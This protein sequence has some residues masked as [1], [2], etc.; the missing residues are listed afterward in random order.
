MIS[1]ADKLFIIDT[2]SKHKAVRVLLFGSGVEASRES[3]DIDLG[4]EGIPPR[5][6]F[7]FYGELIFGLSKPVDLVDITRES[8][9]AH[10][11]RQE[12]ILLYD[13]RHQ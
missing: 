3:R 6:F 2:A 7:K 1:E 8:R 11:I 5:D 9:F 4:V 12:G 13:G 10:L